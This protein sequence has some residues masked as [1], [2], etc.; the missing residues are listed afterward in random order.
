VLCRDV[1]GLHRGDAVTKAVRL[2]FTDL[3]VAWCEGRLPT[4]DGPVELR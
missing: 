3:K 4:L 1:L 2:R